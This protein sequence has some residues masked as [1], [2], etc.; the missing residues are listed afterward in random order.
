MAAEP[1]LVTIATC[2]CMLAPYIALQAG[3]TPIQDSLT[4]DYDKSP[5]HFQLLTSLRMGKFALAALTVTILLSNVLAVALAGLF[6]ATTEKVDYTT[7]VPAYDLPMFDG[8]FNVPADEMYFVLNGVLSGLTLPDWTTPEYF[9]LPVTPTPGP[10]A[11]HEYQVST[12]G[13]GVDIECE[14]VQAKLIALDCL[15]PV[16]DINCRPPGADFSLRNSVT[17]DNSCWSKNSSELYTTWNG[18]SRD[19]LIRSDRCTD[20]FFAMWMEQPGNPHPQMNQSRQRMDIYE[21]YLEAVILKCTVVDKV[22]SLTA[23]VN[24]QG[25]VLS[26]TDIRSLDSQE[27]TELYR[28]RTASLASGF[29]DVITTGVCTNVTAVKENIQWLNHLIATIEPKTI[30]AVTNLTRIPDVAYIINAF[31]DIYRRLFAINMRLYVDDIITILDRKQKTHT[32]PGK[33]IVI[34]DRVNMST[35]MFYIAAS[36]ILILILVLVGIYWK[37]RAPLGH[38]PQSLGEMYAALY[39]S[40]AKEE[41]GKIRG[42]NSRE[43]ARRL[44]ELGGEYRYGVFDTEGGRHYGVSRDGKRLIDTD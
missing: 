5:P 4:V 10:K 44:E 18:P 15:D 35:Q 19:I 2:Q 27:M 20:I 11:L 1:L 38:V 30:R 29:F 25:Q 12:L 13:I 16:A 9:I 23:T 43:R 8:T 17:V 40:N 26:T 7:Q 3:P 33:A 42:V 36:I 14:T 22:V 34:M 41:C 37:P 39:A 21:D 28:N 6:S 31:D 32:V 24:A